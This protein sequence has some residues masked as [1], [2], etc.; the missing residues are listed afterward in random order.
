MNVDLNQQL[1]MAMGSSDASSFYGMAVFEAE[2]YEKLL[3]VFSHPDYQKV[4]Y[5]D[6]QVI[7]DRSRSQVVAGQFATFV[8]K[9]PK[10]IKVSNCCFM[11]GT[12][13]N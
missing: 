6:E 3:E 10:K 12:C 8:D 13:L 1:A 11:C 5:P 2:S 7:L 4:V 9:T